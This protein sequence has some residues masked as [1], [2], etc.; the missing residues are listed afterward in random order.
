MVSS[1][2][3][4]AIC[5]PVRAHACLI[6]ISSMVSCVALSLTHWERL[7]LHERRPQIYIMREN[8]DTLDR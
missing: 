2:G 3:L 8:E 4:Y 1:G 5:N 6:T 7:A